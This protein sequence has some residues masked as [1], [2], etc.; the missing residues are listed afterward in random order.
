MPIVGECLHP[1]GRPERIETVEIIIFATVIAI[2]WF[3]MAFDGADSRD[4]KSVV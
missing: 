2:I 3:A 4:R 1:G